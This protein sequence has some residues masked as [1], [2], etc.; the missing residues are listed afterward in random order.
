MDFPKVF[1]PLVHSFLWI[2]HKE[3]RV[4]EAETIKFI[5]YWSWFSFKKFSSQ[6]NM[7]SSL[8]LHGRTDNRLKP[9]EIHSFVD[10]KPLR[11][12]DRNFII[13]GY[14]AGKLFGFWNAI[15]RLHPSG[16]T[17]FLNFF[18]FSDLNICLKFNKTG[19]S[20]VVADKTNE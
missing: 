17:Q 19:C 5:N 9:F 14:E 11:D 13:C 8:E 7:S 15:F 12:P 10:F 20:I 4:I 18:A 1:A 3:K 2:K 16:T 6:R